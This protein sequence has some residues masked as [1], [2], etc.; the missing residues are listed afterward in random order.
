MNVE[1]PLTFGELLKRYLHHKTD[2]NQR[3]LAKKM[4]I[5]AGYLSMIVSGK[6]IPTKQIV[7]QLANVLCLTPREQEKLYQSAAT[8][9]HQHDTSELREDWGEA[10]R[11]RDFYGRYQELTELKQWAVNDRCRVVAVLGLGG[12]GKTALVAKSVEQ[13]KHEF[14][15]VFWRSLQN[16]PSLESFL[17]TCI[18]FLSDQRRIDLPDGTDSQISVLIQYLQDHRCLLVVDNFDS[19][20]QSGN[21][22]SRWREG[23]EGYGRLIERVGETNHRSCLLLTSRE[24]PK[25][26]VPLEGKTA[27]IHSLY[28]HGLGQL[29]GQELLNDKG[30]LGSD[31]N[32][33]ELIRLYS[34]NPL[35]LK[36]ASEPIRELFEG[37]IASFLEKEKIVFGDIRDLLDLQ[38]AHLSEL[39]REIMYWLAIE[40]EAVSLDDLGEDLVHPVS[41]AEFLETLGYLKRRSMIEVSGTEHFTLQPVILEFVTDGLVERV[42]KEIEAETIELFG[43]HALIK[44][45][46]KVYVRESQVRLIL[47][48]I[49]QHLLN[50]LGKEELEKKFKS[51]LSS[52]RKMH[53]QKRSYAA[54]NFLNLLVQSKYDLRGY[55]FSHLMVWQAY[56]QG[57][58]LPEVNFAHA[59]L[60]T[61]VFTDTFGIILSVVFSPNGE[62]VAAGTANGEIRLWHVTSGTLLRTYQGHTD[63][64]DSIAFSPDGKVLASSSQDRTIRLWEVSTGHCLNILQGHSSWVRSI[65]FSPDGKALASGSQDRTIRLWEV[66]TGHCLNILQGHSSWIYSV[67][68]SPDG[69]ILASG[70]SDQTIRLWDIS[71]GHCLKTLQG[72]TNQVWAVAFSPDGKALASG[73]EDQTVRLWEVSSG[74][75]LKALQGHTNLVYSVAFSPDGETLASSSGDR[76]VRLWEVSTGHCLKTLQGH[77]SWIRSVAFSPDG[78]TVASGGVDQTIRLWDIS[79]GHCLK[80]LQGHTNWLW[81]VA[82][83]PDG[84]TVASGGEDQ[85]VRL[86]EVSTGHCLKTLQGHTNWVY[87]VA[88]S[89]DGKTLASGSEDRTLRLWDVSSGQCLKSLPG[90]HHCIWSVAFSP[91]GRFLASGSDDQTIRLW[92]ISTGHCLKTLQE[93]TNRVW[94]VAFSPDGKTLAS[95]SDDQT[96]RLWEARTGHCL[97]ILQ[98]HTDWIFS[99]AFSP[100]GKT[101]ASGSQDRTVRLWEVSTGQ[102][103]KTLQGHTDWIRSVAFSPDGKTLASGSPDQTVRLW[104]VSTGHCLN[105]LQG[106]SSWVYSVAF[107]LDGKVLAS[108]S[109]DG[110]IKLWNV[111]T[112]EYLKTLRSDRPYECMN[113]TGL[114]G[115]TEAQKIALKALGAMEDEE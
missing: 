66:S 86:W 31:E 21:R 49:A 4:N 51:M 27:S 90:H 87:S 106:H 52:L 44:A 115:L 70:S 74:Q 14:D 89:P 96:I 40:R 12:V 75:Y 108:G 62:L 24:K 71:T 37:N 100:D 19:V 55:D 69:S 113:I 5:S 99:V 57:V 29:E 16:T 80:T 20:L 63:W 58:A 28:L 109:T 10:P 64:V 34:G 54:G 30:L 107:S 61:S 15:Y 2:L 112:G 32:W 85:T 56:L 92:E 82:F 36:L 41:N 59:D 60:A 7:D 50:I 33:S 48:P 95:G 25:E 17:K 47:M 114:K 67:A 39:E 6:R 101:L 94:S 23:C 84:R 110:T 76:T 43:S 83:S 38:F 18:Q 3:E 98:G 53:S 103:L 42:S 65:T 81:S 68:F 35:A 22:G 13:N 45:Q 11:T 78:R 88:F 105:I 73:S 9:K 72:H 97:N 8:A 79:T 104:E 102:C 46:A 111:Q 1:A 93:H 91:D 26:I 77:S